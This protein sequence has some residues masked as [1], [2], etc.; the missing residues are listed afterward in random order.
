MNQSQVQ[1]NLSEKGVN[2]LDVL[3]DGLDDIIFLCTGDL[4][5]PNQDTDPVDSDKPKLI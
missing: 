2:L 4:Y 1:E 3:L 5:M